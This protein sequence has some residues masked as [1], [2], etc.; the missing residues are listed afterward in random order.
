[1]GYSELQ[2]QLFPHVMAFPVYDLGLRG[3][4]AS[5]SR[6]RMRGCRIAAD[7]RG[8]GLR[9]LRT[10]LPADAGPT[11]VGSRKRLSGGAGMKGLG[12]QAS[13]TS[14]DPGPWTE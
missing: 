3:F 2:L 14:L 13:W 10:C 11:R 12:F 5:G 8:A 9:C 1:M 6:A 7:D 4:R